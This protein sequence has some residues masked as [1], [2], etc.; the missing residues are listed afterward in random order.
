[1]MKTMIIG[2]GDRLYISVRC[3]QI[4]LHRAQSTQSMCLC[5]L[6]P[7]YPSVER[8]DTAHSQAPACKDQGPPTSA[9][10]CSA[11]H[12]DGR[13]PQTVDREE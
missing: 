2:D 4:T 12:A 7:W 5:E 1:M 13:R 6:L 3:V 8:T 11:P 9:D 10:L